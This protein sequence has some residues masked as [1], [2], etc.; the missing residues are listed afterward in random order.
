MPGARFGFCTML[1]NAIS[2]LPPCMNAGASLSV[3]QLVAPAYSAH[4][5]D[6]VPRMFWKS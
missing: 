3:L 4:G 1:R 6:S 2:V 5:D